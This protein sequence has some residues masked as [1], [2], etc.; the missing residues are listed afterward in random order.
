MYLNVYVGICF[1]LLNELIDWPYIYSLTSGIIAVLTLVLFFLFCVFCC[2][3][4]TICGFCH[5]AQ[6]GP[7]E[8]CEERF[9]LHSDGRRSVCRW[10][11]KKYKEIIKVWIQP[12][13]AVLKNVWFNFN[14]NFFLWKI[15]PQ[16][17]SVVKYIDFPIKSFP[18]R[19]TWKVPE[20]N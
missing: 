7:Q 14:F 16:S 13:S 15:K 6:P 4:K 3:G 12:I 1:C 5:F 11:V 20:T 19:V 18:L 9:R 8:V 17:C 10:T 2:S